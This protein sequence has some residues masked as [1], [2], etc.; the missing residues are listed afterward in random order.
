VTRPAGEAGFTL[1]E[2]TVT[3]S[4]MSIVTALFST[5]IVQLFSATNNNEALAVATAQLHNAF[6]RLDRDIRYASGISKPGSA[7]AG[8]NEYVEYAITNT[9]TTV[10]TQ[11]RL[12]V[13]TGLL[14]TR[15]KTG[16][17]PASAWSTLA[18]YLTSASSFTRVPASTSTKPFQQL[19][20]ALRA[21]V[22]SSST[23]SATTGSAKSQ[24]VQYTFT[25]LNTS[26]TTAS[27]GVCNSLART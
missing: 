19:D 12:V 8:G 5:A 11:L 1:M 27:D 3:L 17:G 24:T 13:S 4:L 16:A 25:A 15:S 7:G 21:Q 23:G 10:C 2:V 6:V 9:G 18:S 14:Q 26:P 22:G 20:V